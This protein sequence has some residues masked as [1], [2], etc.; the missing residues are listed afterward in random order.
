MQKLPV[1]YIVPVLLLYPAIVYFADTN[2]DGLVNDDDRVPIGN[3][4]PKF[5]GGLNLDATYK[6][7]DF[8]VY[9]YGSEGNKILNYV[10]S[11]LESLCIDEV[12]MELRM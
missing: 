9:F 11:N 4:Q 10:E 5:Y 3:P 8:N 1:V 7:W 2:G 12:Q 6:A